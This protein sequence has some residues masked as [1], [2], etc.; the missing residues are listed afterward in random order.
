MEKVLIFGTGRGAQKFYSLIGDETFTIIGFLDNNRSKWN[1]DFKGYNIYSPYMLIDL[2]FDKIIICSV[3]YTEIRNQL[4]SNYGIP[5]IK[6]ENNLYYHKKNLL[7]FYKNK[8]NLTVEIQEA[9]SNIEKRTLEAINYDFVDKYKKMNIEVFKDNCV[10][11]FYVYYENKKMYMKRSFDTVEKVRWYCS[12]IF[13]EQAVESPHRYLDDNFN[14]SEHDVVIDV[15]AAE[16]NFAISIIDKVNKLYLAEVDPEW[17][18]ALQYTFAPYKNKVFYI[19]K[20]VTDK[21]NDTCTTIDEILKETQINF[22]KMDIEGEE[23]KAL[24]GAEYSLMNRNMKLAICAYHNE[25]D[26]NGIKNICSKFGYDFT[27]PKGYMVFITENERESRTEPIKLV[28]GILRGV[29]NV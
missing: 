12:Y 26:E 22:I 1:T 28:R 14:V 5:E 3:A 8:K 4:I 20:F 27:S 11:L 13:L 24:K 16:G 10:D 2:K 23:I 15:G 21:V 6:I 18:E 9:L 19:N 7:E 17:I 25:N 29:K